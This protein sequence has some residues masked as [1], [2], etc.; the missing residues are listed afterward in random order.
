MK[1]LTQEALAK[2]GEQALINTYSCIPEAPKGFEFT[3]EFRTPNEG[4]WVQWASGQASVAL[5]AWADWQPHLILR[6]VKRKVIRFV[7][8]HRGVPMEGEWLDREDK[9]VQVRISDDFVNEY[10]IYTREKT[11]E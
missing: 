3:G 4:E 5:R 10:D 9:M 2:I 7:F 8:S 11:E 6:P 1:T